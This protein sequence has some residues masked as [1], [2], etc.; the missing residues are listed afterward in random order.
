MDDCVHKNNTLYGGT[1][2]YATTFLTLPAMQ[3]SFY[4]LAV[5]FMWAWFTLNKNKLNVVVGSGIIYIGYAMIN[6]SLS[7]ITRTSAAS[8]LIIGVGCIFLSTLWMLSP[9]VD[10]R[11]EGWSLLCL[12]AIGYIWAYTIPLL[13][14]AVSVMMVL[15]NNVSSKQYNIATQ[16]C[17]DN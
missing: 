2:M 11:V 6:L 4:I 5:S 1:I 7:Y 3:I 12:M 8:M 14:F 16:N 13:I 10:Y 15:H 9:K 17:L